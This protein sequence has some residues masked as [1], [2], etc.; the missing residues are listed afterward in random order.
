MSL[1]LSDH[2]GVYLSLHWLRHSCI[3]LNIPGGTGGLSG[4]LLHQLFTLRSVSLFTDSLKARSPG[5]VSKEP[6]HA[7]NLGSLIDV[8]SKPTLRN[9]EPPP[10]G[11]HLGMPACCSVQALSTDP[12]AQYR[13]AVPIW[14]KARTR[15]MVPLWSLHHQPAHTSEMG[16]NNFQEMPKVTA[17]V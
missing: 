1:N 2:R 13:C 12:S 10:S 14:P 15:I 5:P 16:S 11:K 6:L 17:W 4:A 3:T 8:H 9:P 7:G